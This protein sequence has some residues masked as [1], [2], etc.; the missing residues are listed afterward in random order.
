M[1]FQ[2]VDQAP[3]FAVPG[4]TFTT[5]SSPTL[6]ARENAVWLVRMEPGRP[7]APHRVSREETFVALSG[8][9]HAWID[10]Q[11]HD[12]AAGS[13]LAVPAGALLSVANPGPETFEAIAVMPVGAV[14]SMGGEAPFVPPWAA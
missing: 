8:K 1:H 4:A 11:R 3:R 2:P 7:G 6:G 12:L 13:V 14:V 10:G 5:L 9:A